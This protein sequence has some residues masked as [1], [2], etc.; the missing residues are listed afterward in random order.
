MITE[1]LINNA[2]EN[3]KSLC[4]ENKKLRY[5]VNILLGTSTLFGVV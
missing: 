1:E 5:W 2:D 3:V 4:V